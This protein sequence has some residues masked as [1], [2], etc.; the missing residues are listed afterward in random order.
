MSQ[1]VIQNR[2]VV[3][4]AAGFIGYHIADSLSKLTSQKM[5]IVDNFVRG[6]RDK[7]FLR[8]IASPNIEFIERDLSLE[9]SYHGLFEGD[10]IVINCAAMN[11][12][13]NFYLN[14]TGVVRHSAISSILAAEYAAS[15]KVSKY[16][17]FGTPESYAGAIN[18]GIA[19]IPTSEA[20]PLI[21]DDPLN[22]RWSY[23]ASKTIG[24][25]ATIANHFQFGLNA[26]IFRIHNIYG[27]RMGKDHVVPDLVTK[28]LSGSFEVYGVNESRTF[29]YIDDLVN[30]LKK[31]ISNN[32]NDRALIYNV[33]SSKEIQIK[34][35]AEL[36]LKQ[37][38]LGKDIIPLP[39]LKGSVLRRV[40]D[41][42]LLRSIIEFEETDLS[43][44]ISK[45][46][47]WY[48]KANK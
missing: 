25:I 36:I 34:S 24:E 39:S 21:I 31:F 32:F 22:L 33:G 38:N 48:L 46:I 44:G 15:A 3:L 13:K 14:S 27:P 42:T 41:V 37:M 20:V 12:T 35:L 45:Y 40:P 43:I 10:D 16:I 5:L 9:V 30:I 29:M 17:Y 47:E 1:V 18:L 2:V 7:E 6:V 11:G 23:A 28:F 8:L 4:G 19:K 26:I